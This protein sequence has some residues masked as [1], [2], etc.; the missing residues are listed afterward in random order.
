MDSRSLGCGV[1]GPH[2][3]VVRRQNINGAWS[4]SRKAW[5]LPVDFLVVQAVD[6]YVLECHEILGTA[7]SDFLLVNLLPPPALG[8]P[9][10]SRGDRGVA[11]VAAEAGGSGTPGRAADVPA[12]DG[13]QR[14]RRRRHA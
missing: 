14:R 4:K 11:R 9:G 2:L 6:Q 7:G 1:E 5:V 10:V 3:H 12:R 8:L 13:Q